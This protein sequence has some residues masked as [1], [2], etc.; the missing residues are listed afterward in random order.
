MIKGKFLNWILLFVVSIMSVN[1]VNAQNNITTGQKLSAKQQS[2]ITI[3]SY[4]AQGDL[5]KL[6]PVLHTGLD[7]GL[8]VNQIREAIVHLYAYCGFPRSIRGLQTLMK[9]LDERKAKGIHDEWGLGAVTDK[10]YK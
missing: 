10:E 4:T 6:Q 2:I 9:V 7:N 5:E 3:A 1:T 8:T